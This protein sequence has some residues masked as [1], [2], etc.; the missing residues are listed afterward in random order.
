MSAPTDKDRYRFEQNVFKVS[1]EKKDIKKALEEW[2]LVDHKINEDK[3]EKF[4]CICNSR[5]WKEQYFYY[6]PFTKFPIFVGSAC[7][8]KFKKHA[9]PGMGNAAAR[10]MLKDILKGMTAEE[11]LQ[12]K[13]I[14]NILAYCRG[15]IDSLVE[16][17]EQKLRAGTPLALEQLIECLTGI[18]ERQE[19]LY[20][21]SQHIASL[22]QRLK[23]RLQYLEIQAAALEA[24]AA[25]RRAKEAEEAAAKKVKHEAFLA[26]IAARRQKEAEE[27]E[28]RRAEQERKLQMERERLAEQTA[29]Y[30]RERKERQQ[31]EEAARKERLRQEE[32]EQRRV[33]AANWQRLSS[34]EEEA[35]RILQDHGS[36]RAYYEA[37][38]QAV[39]A[40]KK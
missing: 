22:L 8:E 38:A 5:P 10:D 32:E 11:K 19:Q 35:A 40:K 37:L 36:K 21:P 24:E 29:R 4:H 6:N 23:D 39:A 30:E 1:R 13:D 2:E 3:N 27:T 25:V 7:A 20:L 33:Y 28:A 12:Y 15:V 17:I 31:R 18:L 14:A 9:K 26:A 34:Q 16:H